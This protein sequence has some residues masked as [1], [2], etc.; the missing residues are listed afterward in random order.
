MRAKQFILREYSREKTVNVFGN[1]IITALQ[2]DRSLALG[3][4][5]LGTAREYL[6]QKAKL[7][8]PVEDSNKIVII[9]D[10][11]STLENADPTANKEY[12]Q[13]LVKTYANAGVKME[14]LLARGRPS[15]EMYNRF[16]IKKILPPEYRDIGRLDFNTLEGIVQDPGLLQALQ[17]KEGQEAAKTMPKGESKVVFDNEQVRIIVPEDTEAACY[18]GQGTRW[19]TAA[20]E[21]NMFDRYNSDGPMYIMLPK[22]PAY[23]GEKYQ[24]HFDSGQYMDE[25]DRPVPVLKLITE[26]FG[27]LREFFK[28]REPGMDTWIMF[29]DDSVIDEGVRKIREIAYD[30]LHEILSDWEANDDYY[31]KWL[32]EQGYWNEA[33]GEMDW[34]RVA[35][36]N[37]SYLSYNDE[38][39]DFYNKA[40]DALTLPAGAVRQ[41]AADL[42]NEHRDGEPY[43]LS[44]LERVIAGHIEYEFSNRRGRAEDGGLADFINEKIWV[45]YDPNTK[46]IDAG[47][48]RQ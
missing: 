10:I 13:W 21:N 35:E 40:E 37:V 8:S 14:D 48:V 7:N 1:K 45:K 44:E 11:M 5:A 19:C 46:Q 42:A 24:L 12:V 4:T 15:L 3:G 9:N 34:D 29:A 38:A 25:Q 26:R 47:I 20:R 30:F 31:Y 16:K 33:E 18:Y 41:V 39:G 36:D 32:E 28:G 6:K 27:D 23:A 17:D 22:Q 2:N 43:D